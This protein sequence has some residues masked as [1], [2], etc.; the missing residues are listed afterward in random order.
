MFLAT[1]IT[2]KSSYSNSS[3]SYYTLE[4]LLQ[5]IDEIYL[6]G[7]SDEGWH[8]KAIVH[9]FINSG[10]EVNVDIFPYPKLIAV[11]S[12][13]YEKYVRSSPNGSTQDNLLNLPRG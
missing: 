13:N 2:M 12:K 11:V 4:G 6:T 5:E 9:D 8:K 7:V 3:A 10:H 1:Q